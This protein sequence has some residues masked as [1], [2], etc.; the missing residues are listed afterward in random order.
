[1]TGEALREGL[2]STE[3]IM[4][5]LETARGDIFLSACYLRVTARE[6][7]SYIRSSEMLQAY[8]GMIDK[9]KTDANYD[10]LSNEQF[11]SQLEQMSKAYKV[12]A[13]DII[14]DMARMPFDSAAMAEVKLKAAI[15]LR[16][17]DTVTHQNTDQATVLAELN[18]IYQANAPR[19]KSVRAVQIEYQ[20]E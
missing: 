6:L 9:V 17:V 2:I 12:E 18:Q 13:L 11:A 16:G 3:G 5:A 8:V 20:S 10:K 1:M 14:H 4:T 15:Q 19:I 7:D